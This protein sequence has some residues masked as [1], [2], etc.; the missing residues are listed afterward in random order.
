MALNTKKQKKINCRRW[1]LF[2]MFS[3]F[4]FSTYNCGDTA[5]DTRMLPKKIKIEDLVG[6]PSLPLE[7]RQVP[8]SV[9]VFTIPVSWLDLQGSEESL[10]VTLLESLSEIMA[11]IAFEQARLSPLKSRHSAWE[12]ISVSDRTHPE[13]VMFCGKGFCLPLLGQQR[14]LGP[15]SPCSILSSGYWPH[16]LLLDVQKKK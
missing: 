3:L 11:F 8:P 5:Q 16:S 4:F 13:A 2:Q 15:G 10:S 7:R 6:R 9:T 1:H 14:E 12:G